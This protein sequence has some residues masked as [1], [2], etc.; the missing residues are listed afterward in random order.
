MIP[1]GAGPHI[2]VDLDAIAHNVGLLRERAGGAAVMAVLK[3]D[4]Y[5]HGA[6]Q[7]ARTALASGAD[8]LGVATLGEAMAVRQAGVTAPLLAWLHSPGADF[9]SALRADVQIAIASMRQLDELLDAVTETGITATVT[10]KVD[11]GMKRNGVTAAEF[12][13]FL[14]AFARASAA[15]AVRLHGVMS[16]LSHGDE[17]T[18]PAN[19][20][21]AHH[22]RE[23][24]DQVRR[25]GLGYQV[26]HLANSAATMGRPDLAFDLV[27]PGLA[28]YG[29]SPIPQRGDM[30]LIPAMTLSCPVAL[31]KQVSAGDGVS[32]GHTWV[33]QRDTNVA[34]L[35][36]G[37]ADGVFRNLSGRFEVMINGRRYPS[38][39]RICMDQFLVDIGSD[40]DV[41]V[42]DRA[43]LFGSGP[44]EP[45]AQDWAD[46][47]GTISYEVVTSPRGRVTRGNR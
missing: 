4:G 12:P 35:P 34:L 23:M 39:G 33:A 36:I 43:I 29:L 47:L 7:V 45:R 46:T 10:V 13:T 25:A 17:P 8:A 9:A 14:A 1:R 37:Y 30:G 24:C 22:L 28:V 41:E 3:A 38:V 42:D 11:T 21:Q 6:A 16:H 31:V 15:G 18:H 44:G 26:T 27:R 20:C 2:D 40:H 5:G 19:D 32:Y